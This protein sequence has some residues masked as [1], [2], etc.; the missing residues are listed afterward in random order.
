MT[1]TVGEAKDDLQRLKDLIQKSIEDYQKKNTHLLVDGS[2]YNTFVEE[3]G[4]IKLH[5]ISVN[6]SASIRVD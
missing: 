5:K 2:F 1:V 6:L 3:N 4:Q